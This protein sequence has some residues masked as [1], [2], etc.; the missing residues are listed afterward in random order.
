MITF[1]TGMPIAR[2]PLAIVRKEIR[3]PIGDLTQD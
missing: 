2:S 3:E 1:R